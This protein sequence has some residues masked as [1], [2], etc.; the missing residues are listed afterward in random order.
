MLARLGRRFREIQLG[1]PIGPGL[2]DLALGVGAESLA[3]LRSGARRDIGENS[4]HN[5]GEPRGR[6]RV[7]VV[8]EVERHCQ[9]ALLSR[10]DRQPD[11][12][13]VGLVRLHPHQA[14]EELQAGRHVPFSFL[15]NDAVG[16]EGH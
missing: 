13:Q 7:L 15:E 12:V 16:R 2:L 11:H 10:R 9:G 4:V 5:H 8:I 3:L 1:A 14:C 6:S